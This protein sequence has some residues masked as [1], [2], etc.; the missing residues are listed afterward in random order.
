MRSSS[1][2]RLLIACAVALELS[3][4]ASHACFMRSP[5]PVQVWMDHIQVNI[6]DQ[7][8]VKTYNCTFKNANP[9][10]VVG[11]TCY[12]ELEPGAQVDNMSVLI[13]GVEHQAEI[14]DAEK[15]KEV[16][17]DVVRKGGSP[18]LLEYFGNQL[19]QTQVPR[20]EP[21]GTVTVK[22]QYTTVLPLKG[23]VVRL[24]MLNTNPKALMQSL[25]SASVEVNVK[26]QRPI[27]NVY[28][29]T[30]KITYSEKPGWDVSLSW[31]QENYLPKHPF[32]LY[33]QVAEDKVG[34]SVV[35]HKERREDGAFMLMLSPTV[36]RGAG[37]VSEADILPKDVVFCVDT[38]GS[39]LEA[40][41]MT[42]ARGALAYCVSHL[43]KGDRFNI[44]DFS[45]TARN[46]SD[47]GL[48]EFDD[49]AMQD[50]LD[51]VGDLSARGGT[52]I[53]EALETAIR[54][55][56]NAGKQDSDSRLKMVVFATDGLPT[57][58]ETDAKALLAAV[59]K[60]N[61]VE[62]RL[63]VFGEGYDVNTSL[64]DFL[65]L[66]HRGE[67]DYILPEEDIKEKISRFFDRVGSPIM[68]DLEVDFGDLKTHNVYPR[69]IDDVFRGEQIVVYGRY[70]SGGTHT[71]TVTGNV[72]GRRRTFQYE[73]DFPK[74]SDDDKNAFVHRLWAG[75]KVDYLL[76]E[77][78]KQ[79]VAPDE[80]VTEVT[81]L[82]K[83]YG[84]VTPYTSYLMTNDVIATPQLGQA[85]QLG[86]QLSSGFGGFGGG[87]GGVGLRGI[88]G[89]TAAPAADS[90]A[91]QRAVS[92]AK[93]FNEFRRSGGRSG[94]LSELEESADDAL[95]AGGF[96]YYADVD[97]ARPAEAATRPA[98]SAM[99]HIGTRTFYNSGD[100][101]YE[102]DFD[103]TKS[104]IARTLKVGSD[105]YIKLLLDDSRLAKFFALGDVVLKIDDEWLRIEG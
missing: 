53:E 7:V 14:L 45:T 91:R 38:S 34:A 58:G 73:L 75:R 95:Q 27:K 57:I 8:A 12:M 2:L 20:I 99:R 74:R 48:V 96:G 47:D 4:S 24:Q 36:G 79:D 90:A 93:R 10:A 85:Q 37:A 50:A 88:G 77:I 25:K 87:G 52:A 43:R 23:D 71:I 80:L 16:F 62:A 72:K 81:R 29:P 66:D 46:L 17:T 94:S 68:T 18:A 54:H 84:I 32:V 41:K 13:D 92:S 64:L 5:L 60:Q 55:L 28:S 61:D 49:E 100:V 11:G 31:Q 78:R 82:A 102:S 22:L 103:P 3:S 42:Q 89:G 9:Q 1:L 83:R 63:F 26:S 105:D 56:K 6:T 101:W 98:L 104:K 35:A 51:Y 97:S 39:M 15:A 19:I 65:A 33:Y 86:R 30:H 70:K 40:N 21:N 59:A 67:A 76:N 69:K 44:V